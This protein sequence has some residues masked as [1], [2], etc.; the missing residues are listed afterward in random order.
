MGMFTFKASGIQWE[1]ETHEPL[2]LRFQPDMVDG[3]GA[4]RH[5]KDPVQGAHFPEAALKLTGR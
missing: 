4:Y 3:A 1:I 2:G 5:L